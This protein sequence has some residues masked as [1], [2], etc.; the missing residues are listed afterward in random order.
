MS[1]A[2]TRL[3]V[4]DG[5]DDVPDAVIEWPTIG[6]RVRGTERNH[7]PVAKI[8]NLFDLPLGRAASLAVLAYY[9]ENGGAPGRAPPVKRATPRQT[10][11]RAEPTATGCRTGRADRN[12]GRKACRSG[13]L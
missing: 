1:A 12:R 11:A 7:N 2:R 5:E 3:R 10:A 13:P 6:S 9:V 4:S 8:N